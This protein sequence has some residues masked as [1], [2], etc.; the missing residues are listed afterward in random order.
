MPNIRIY[1]DYTPNTI[2]QA[3]EPPPEIKAKQKRFEILTITALV[4]LFVLLSHGLILVTARIVYTALSIKEVD[5]FF[6]G[7]IILAMGIGLWRGYDYIWHSLSHTNLIIA[8]IAEITLLAGQFILCNFS[9]PHMLKYMIIFS[10]ICILYVLIFFKCKLKF[11]ALISVAIVSVLVSTNYTHIHSFEFTP[12]Y[13]YIS[14]SG[15]QNKIS[16][17][18]NYYYEEPVNQTIDT[19]HSIDW[20]LDEINYFTS[21]TGYIECVEE[22][23]DGYYLKYLDVISPKDLPLSDIVNFNGAY[24][25]TF[26]KKNGICITVVELENPDDTIKCTDFKYSLAFGKPIIEYTKSKATAKDEKAICI[27]VFEIPDEYKE[28]LF[29]HTPSFN[30]RKSGIRYR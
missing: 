7:I 15:Y 30:A 8:I 19:K 9:V 24:D 11:K 5:I 10:A 29:F 13:I 27:I 25:D 18:V 26:F 4:L 17:E 2:P 3:Y 14:S 28:S 12:R 20:L 6:T 23:P 21:C 22:I 1:G 16:N